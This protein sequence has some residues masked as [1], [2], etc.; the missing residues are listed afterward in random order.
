MKKRL[1][2]KHHLGEYTEWGH[3]LVILRNRQDGFDEFLNAFIE[4]E[5]KMEFPADS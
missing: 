5:M 2:K 4:I 3:P 1:R